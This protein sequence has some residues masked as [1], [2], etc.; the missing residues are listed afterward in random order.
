[1]NRRTATAAAAAAL[2]TACL[3]PALA[4]AA[5]PSSVV[6]FGESGDY[7]APG[8]RTY[9]GAKQVTLSGSSAGV[10]VSVDGPNQRAFGFSMDFTP[11]RDDLLAP[12][13][14]SGAQRSSFR[15]R[16]R[17]GIDITGDG[18]GCN[19]QAGR[20]IVK[21]LGLTASGKV[22]RLWLLFEQRCEGGRAALFGEVKIGVPPRPG[23]LRATPSA[24]RWPDRRVGQRGTTVPLTFVARRAV[25]PGRA[26][27]RGSGRRAFTVT[28][29]RCRGR[30]MATG[31]RCQVYVRFTP[32]RKATARATLSLQGMGS[33]AQIALTGGTPR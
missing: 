33:A 24:L 3:A 1:M 32:R 28:A 14:Y 13:S 26:A 31:D 30:R 19:E 25:T 9:E 18:R 20:F 5:G 17:P 27:L 15:A 12:G 2:A 29:N 4:L 21:D 11:A 23:P 10:S 6:M 16:G 8:L 7:V 22:N